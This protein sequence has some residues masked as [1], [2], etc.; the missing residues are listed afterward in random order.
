MIVLRDRK[1][2]TVLLYNRNGMQQT[3]RCL[4][5]DTGKSFYAEKRVMVIR[6]I[7][8]VH[9]RPKNEQ[10]VTF[11][12][13]NSAIKTPISADLLSAKKTVATK[14]SEGNKIIFC[15]N[16]VVGDDHKLICLAENCNKI[17]VRSHP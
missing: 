5:K 2:S 16:E 6:N 13:L 9:W 14:Q 4:K 7:T 1:P 15:C 17:F 8:G 3:A 10:V 11:N 12:A